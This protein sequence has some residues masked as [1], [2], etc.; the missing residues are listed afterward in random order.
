[1]LR[2]ASVVRPL[3]ETERE[4]IPLKHRPEVGAEVLRTEIQGVDIP[5]HVTYDWLVSILRRG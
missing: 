4:R 2:R 5:G 3:T 1:M